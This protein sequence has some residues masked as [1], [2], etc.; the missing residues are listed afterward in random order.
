MVVGLTAHQAA[1]RRDFEVSPLGIQECDNWYDPS[2]MTAARRSG[3]V[4]S[5][6]TFRWAT[7]R[8]PQTVRRQWSRQ[9]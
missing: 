5:V 9:P 8:P 6:S 2:R 1:V 4:G 3:V 7:I